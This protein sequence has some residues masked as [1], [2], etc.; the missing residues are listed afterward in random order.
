MTNHLQF[1]VDLLQCTALIILCIAVRKLSQIIIT[2]VKILK[3][4]DHNS[5][6]HK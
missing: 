6:T 1:I 4:H 3:D 5:P 2:L